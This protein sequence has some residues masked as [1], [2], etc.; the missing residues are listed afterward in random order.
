[1]SLRHRGRQLKG[2][3]IDSGGKKAKKKRLGEPNYSREK[4]GFQPDGPRKICPEKKKR[5]NGCGR[6]VPRSKKLLGGLT[7]KGERPG[8]KKGKNV[9]KVKWKGGKR[10]KRSPPVSGNESGGKIQSKK[11]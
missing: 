8:G 2:P 10:V 6:K 5:E 9:K 3:Y 11:G 1:V 7:K 4:G